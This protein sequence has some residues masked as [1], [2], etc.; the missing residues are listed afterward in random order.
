[1]GPVCVYA[2]DMDRCDGKEIYPNAST[3]IWT[4]VVQQKSSH[5]NNSATITYSNTTLQK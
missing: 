2:L 3:G 5:F 4:P 1:M